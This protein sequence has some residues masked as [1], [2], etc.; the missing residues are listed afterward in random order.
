M[1]N[2]RIRFLRLLLLFIAI[3]AVGTIGYVLIEGWTW[4][5]SLY[6]TA[7]TLSTVGFGEIRPLGETGRIFTIILIFAGVGLIFF[8]LSSMAEYL[9]SFNMEYELRKR[10]SSNMIKNMKDHVIVCGFG[11][12]GSSAAAALQ[13]NGKQIVVIDVNP[14]RVNFAHERG[15]AVIEGDATQDE[16]LSKA[17]VERSQSIIVSMGDDSLNLFIV[18]SARSINPD[19]YIIAR[20]NQAANAEKLRRAGANRVVSPYEI[21]G[22]HM[23]NIVIRPHVTDFFDV[24]TLPGGEEIWVEE[25]TLGPGSSL[26]GRSVV[27]ADIRRQTGVTLIAIYR[28]ATQ[29]NFLPDSKSKLSE[30]DKLIVLG[31]R[32]QLASLENL[33]RPPDDHLPE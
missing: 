15:L 4:G 31:T 17:G 32:D 12:V 22:Q 6:M 1:I 3:I 20:A 26:V 21:G 10:R 18:L 23:A 19:L 28:P 33:T 30:G 25:Q 5:D 7:I 2:P 14:E 13:E 8:S 9:V 29:T 16:T 11:Q 27:E 24:V